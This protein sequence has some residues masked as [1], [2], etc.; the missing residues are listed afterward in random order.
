MD[1][2]LTIGGMMKTC[3][4]ACPKVFIGIFVLT[5]NFQL[6]TFNCFSSE[7]PAME[8]RFYGASWDFKKGAE[9]WVPGN[10]VSDFETT[11]EGA[12]FTVIEFDPWITGPEIEADAKLFKNISIR[13]KAPKKVASGAIYFR[14]DKSPE[15]ATPPKTQG[16]EIKGDDQ[17]HT[18]D[19]EM[20]GL[21]DWTGNVLQIRLDP[22][23]PDCAGSEITIES[24]RI[25]RLGPKLD[26]AFG[27]SRGLVGAGET[28]K[29]S[30]KIASKGGEDAQSVKASLVLPK[31]V[32]LVSGSAALSAE[33]LP[34]GEAI[35]SE[36]E[37]R[38]EK[39]GIYTAG[40]KA[41]AADFDLPAQNITLNVVGKTAA[42]SRAKPGKAQAV[43]DE[44]KNVILEND[45]MRLVFPK[46]T[47][48]YLY[49]QIYCYDDASWF[50]LGKGYPLGSIKYRSKAGDV[51]EA[52]LPQSFEV[53]QNDGKTASVKFPA[54]I[55]D[56]DGAVWN[57]A[58]TFILKDNEP[59]VSVS[60]AISADKDREVLKFCG[61]YIYAGEGSFGRQKTEAIFPGLE[62]LTAEESSSSEL[63]IWP[64]GNLRHTPHPYKVTIPVMAVEYQK[65]VLGLLWEP[66]QKWDGKNTYPS[67]RFCSPNWL[68]SQDNHQMG[69]FVPSIPEWVKEN[70]TE[71]MTAYQLKA[72][73]S[74]TISSYIL[75]DYPQTPLFACLR[76]FDI[77]GKPVLQEKPMSYEDEVELTK[78]AYMESGIWDSKAVGWGHV[79]TWKPAQ[80]QFDVLS[81]WMYSMSA[82]NAAEKQ[83]TRERAK[84]VYNYV[85]DEQGPQ[86][87][88]TPLAFRMGSI[89]PS[90]QGLGNS[91]KGIAGS[92]RKDGSW[93]F[94]PDAQRKF[95]GKPG[96]EE[97][98][99]TAPNAEAVLRYAR[100]TGN[101]EALAKGLKALESMEKF[102]IPRAA[103]CWECPVHS[104][105]IYASAKITDAYIEGYRATGDKKYLDRAVYWAYTGIPFTYFWTAPDRPVMKYSTIPI[106][107]ATAFTGSW[108]GVP[109]LWNGLCYAYA[110]QHL[111]EYDKSF[112]WYTLAEGIVISG[113]VQQEKDGK[114]KGCYTDNWNLMG[115]IKCGGCLINPEQI[116]KNIYAFL[117]E[118]P[119]IHTTILEKDGSKIFLNT[120]GKISAA[121]IDSK[122]LKF[123]LAYPKD[124]TSFCVIA[125][126]AKPEEVLKDGSALKYA[127]DL[128]TAGEGWKYGDFDSFTYLKI[129]HK[130]P[131]A[132]I[133]IGN[134]AVIPPAVKIPAKYVPHVPKRVAE[135]KA[136]PMKLAHNWEF[137]KKDVQ[138]LWSSAQKNS[139]SDL[140]FTQT[141]MKFKV[142]GGDP[143]I[144]FPETDFDGSEYK[145]VMLRAKGTK[146]K[147][148]GHAIYFITEDSPNWGEDKRV[149]ANA[150]GDDRFHTYTIDMAQIGA[151]S[152]KITGAR[153]DM[154]NGPDEVDCEV[155]IEFIKIANKQQ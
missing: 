14:T 151:W 11:K 1:Y 121:A 70:G 30:A 133:L 76:Y 79:Y 46:S 101:K 108:I 60:S 110:L 152:A 47:M 53:L 44:K 19:I 5:F 61:P 116:I 95:L 84:L 106:F 59:W 26:I 34:V 127:E 56:K 136:K 23:P 51:N 120:G 13:M 98:G 138:E 33:K 83:K 89:E 55:K 91:T 9:G 143:Y 77:F 109:V 24:I 144:Y 80:Y 130:K 31:E 85:L 57:F 22:E 97:A 119:D 140:E 69:I 132:E 36:W 3:L 2:G 115:D 146:T 7:E 67:A 113:M 145:Y 112:P 117:G 40:L 102:T 32:S 137:A 123:R 100:M 148:S 103:Q 52:I 86:A 39:D 153:L 58:V 4:R 12:K 104:P 38:A 126:I 17:F 50:D 66:L 41:S 105:D 16:F 29:I 128:E 122:A 118:D 96:A 124:E 88:W 64:P 63:D 141:S 147:G 35:S 149:S 142:T 131:E 28:F 49:Y 15:W 21:K 43:A 68:E 72:G 10:A 107:G 37:V 155:E 18:Y 27:S 94:N 75:A 71:A 78:Y 99:L 87:I 150:I 82:K 65:R 135:E 48:G 74:L 92:Q 42:L 62:W 139:I 134:P 154:F 45:R 125:G 25:Y 20:S 6:L 90:M 129:E 8:K 93:R 114:A 73:A 111:W 54:V 81:L